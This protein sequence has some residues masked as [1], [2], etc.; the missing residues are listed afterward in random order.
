M[1]SY[2][3]LPSSQNSLVS[4]R[5]FLSILTAHAK[6]TR[7][8]LELALQR[9]QALS[10]LG[11]GGDGSDERPTV[12]AALKYLILLV[13]VNELFDVALGTYDFQL[14]LMVAEKSQK[15]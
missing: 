9:I 1:S 5:F 11:P 15:V 4:S 8:E 3:S 12:D 2:V 14:V 10:S 6:K 7:P 13:D